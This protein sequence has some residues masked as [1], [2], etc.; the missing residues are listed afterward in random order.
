[1]CGLI[2]EDRLHSQITGDTVRYITIYEY[3]GII[4]CE[5]FATAYRAYGVV[6]VR[7][8]V[9]EVTAT[10]E[11]FDNQLGCT[12][13]ADPHRQA[14]T[15]LAHSRHHPNHGLVDR[16][17]EINLRQEVHDADAKSVGQIKLAIIADMHES[18]FDLGDT[19]PVNLPSRHFQSRRE[20]SLSQFQSISDAPYLRTDNVLK[21]RHPAFPAKRL[22]REAGHY[23]LVTNGDTALIPFPRR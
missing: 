13:N 6:P 10:V 9:V 20:V 12:L 5:I 21:L 4:E 2:I 23:T 11:P 14:E 1:M 18:R 17:L 22:P 19:R 8:P 7:Y 3:S 16:L 15:W